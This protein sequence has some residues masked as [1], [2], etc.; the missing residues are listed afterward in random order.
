MKRVYL[1]L[2]VIGAVVPYIFFAGFIRANGLDLP[3]FVRGLFAS[4]PAAGFTADLLITSA[5]FW[6]MMFSEQKRGGPNPLIFIALNLLAGLS[7]A[8]PA[9]LYARE[10]GRMA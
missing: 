5:I 7:C 3:V 1:V 2:A 9:Y 4:L 8:L 6:L 10:E